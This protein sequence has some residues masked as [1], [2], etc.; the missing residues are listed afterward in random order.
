MKYKKS[1]NQ[2]YSTDSI[3]FLV[4][5][6]CFEILVYSNLGT[7]YTGK[8]LKF[9]VKLLPMVTNGE[10]QWMSLKVNSFTPPTDS[11]RYRMEVEAATRALLQS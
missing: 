8:W 6:K 3:W 10:M 7:N 4:V 1:S 9:K 2:V 11:P 5:T